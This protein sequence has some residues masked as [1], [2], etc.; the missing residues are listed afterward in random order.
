MLSEI[1]LKSVFRLALSLFGLIAQPD[2]L[3]DFLLVE[4]FKAVGGDDV[5]VVLLGEE[6]AGL[7]QALAVERV[8]ILEYLADA[9]N[10]YMLGEYLLAAL[11]K[12]RH[13]E[14]I[15]QLLK[16]VRKQGK[17][18]GEELVDVLGLD[19]DGVGVDVAQE[20]HEEV[21]RHVVVGRHSLLFLCEV[22]GE[23]GLEVS[24]T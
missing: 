6:Q 17:T 14:P 3:D 19:F 1:T 10:G 21:V 15:S 2:D 23:R 12:R 9:L 4:V 11:L 20:H 16:C 7:L 13:I 18:Y 24:R 5:V 8:S 22:V